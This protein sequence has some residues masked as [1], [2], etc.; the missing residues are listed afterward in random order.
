MLTNVSPS[1]FDYEETLSTLKYADRAKKVRMR[2]NANVTSGL[3]ATD[4]SAV[5]LVPLLQAEVLKLKE[6]L[7]LQQAEQ[8]QHRLI[9][10]LLQ[11]DVVTKM[12][13]RVIELEKQL[14]ERESLIESLEILR[15]ESSR[16]SELLS[17]GIAARSFIKKRTNG[18]SSRSHPVVVLSD[19]AVD[20]SMH[21]IVNLNQD[22]LFSECLVY[23]I[24]VG[25]IL[26]GS[27]ESSANVL[28][29][30]PDILP[31]HCFIHNDGENLTLEPL[32]DAAVYINGERLP[33][34]TN[35]DAHRAL[36]HLDRLAF[37]R[38]HL[39]RF[40]AKGCDVNRGTTG[41]ANR[42]TDIPGWEF[43]Q[44][45]LLKNLNTDSTQQ[46]SWSRRYDSSENIRRTLLSN[47]SFITEK[48]TTLSEL[49][50]TL[51]MPSDPPNYLHRQLQSTNDA[52]SNEGR[53]L[54][55]LDSQYEEIFSKARRQLESIAKNAVNA[56][57]VSSLGR[58]GISKSSDSAR[59]A[60][61][62]E[63]LSSLNDFSFSETTV[64]SQWQRV[65]HGIYTRLDENVG[66]NLHVSF[67]G[68]ESE[69]STIASNVT[70]ATTFEKEAMELQAELAH[71]QQTLQD[72][73]KRYSRLI[74]RS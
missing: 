15:L 31:R 63:P 60:Q 67:S 47:Q 51:P 41:L 12:Q 69:H 25:T 6:L 1:A 17:T 33:S 22:P 10:P 20:I 28:V 38:F 19:E 55:N 48:D 36:R 34:N 45:E 3:L 74:Q 66:S 62:H 29:S 18:A 40:D 43:A 65:G 42:R 72:R 52:L 8:M 61:W 49:R 46:I 13:A 16:K 2:V 37:G 68:V 30:G 73:M 64:P 39:F 32:D 11:E 23:Y 35:L 24:Q 71:M 27:D 53:G 4:Q 9:D 58:G 56:Q 21:R 70:G 59:Q 7:R 57:S 44:E 14:A 26:V 50:S 5:D 54:R